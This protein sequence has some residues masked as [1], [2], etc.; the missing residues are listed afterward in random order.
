MLQA[1]ISYWGFDKKFF[2]ITIHLGASKWFVFVVMSWCLTGKWEYSHTQNS[3]KNIYLFRAHTSKSWLSCRVFR[4]RVKAKDI[5]GHPPKPFGQS[6]YWSPNCL[7]VIS[8]VQTHKTVYN[9]QLLRYGFD[10]VYLHD[11]VGP[12]STWVLVL[13]CWN[14]FPDLL[15]YVSTWGDFWSEDI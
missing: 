9:N 7:F 12:C 14:F 2:I 8:E 13:E 3:H 5:I 4:K 10:I 1:I 11:L 6:Y 15:T